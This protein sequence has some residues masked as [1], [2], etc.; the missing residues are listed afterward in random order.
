LLG[1]Q[2]TSV[3]RKTPLQNPQIKEHII[4]STKCIQ[5]EL[6]ILNDPFTPLMIIR[7]SD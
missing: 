4:S 7:I 1:M 5:V 6:K 3:R 2:K